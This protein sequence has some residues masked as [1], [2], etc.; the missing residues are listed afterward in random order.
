MT[1]LVLPFDAFIRTIGIH[2]NSPHALFLGAGASI[3]SGV[4]SA[5]M[6]VWEWKRNIFL[7]NHPGLEDQFSEL[8][9]ESVKIRIQDWLDAQGKFPIQHHP[10][11]YSAFIEAC[12]PIPDSRRAYFQEKVKAAKPFTGY[13]LL[14]LLAE[15]EL[16]RS[17]W[18][19]N[20]DGLTLKSATEFEI[21][22]V[23]VGIDSQERLPRTPTKGELLYIAMHGDYRYDSLMNTVNELRNQEEHLRQQLINLISNT[24]FIFSGYKGGDSSIM[25]ALTTGYSQPGTGALYWCGY[26]AEIPESVKSLICAARDAGRTAYFIPTR[27]FD[28]V[29]SSLARYCLKGESL[30]KAQKIISSNSTTNTSHRKPF[31]I[32][33]LPTNTLIKS[34]AFELVC[35]SEVFAFEPRSW[36]NK[37][38]W[39]W[40]RGITKGHEIVAVPFKR[41]I[42]LGVLDNIKDVFGDLIKGA[43]ERVPVDEHDFLF[44]DGAM[45]SLMK[46][47]L[48][49]SLATYANLNTDGRDILWE[50]SSYKQERFENQNF[51]I[52][53][54]VIVFIRRMSGRL[55]LVLKPSVIITDSNEQP[56]PEEISKILKNKVLSNQYNK[57]FNQ[58]MNCWRIK[59][60]DVKDEVIFEYPPNCGSTFRF[61]VRKAPL[62]AAMGKSGQNRPVTI[63]PEIVPMVKQQGVMIDEPSLVFSNKSGSSLVKDI[64]PI[65][66]L[67][68]ARPY[69]YSLTLQ[70]LVSSISLGIICPRNETRKLHTYLHQS[71][72]RHP[73]PQSMQNHLLD[74][75]GFNTAYGTPLEIPSP[76]EDG[77]ITCP[78]PD[79][80]LD[81][82]QGSLELARFIT[83]GISQLESTQKP[84]VIVIFIPDRWKTWNAFETDDENFDLHDFV[85]AYAVQT[86]VS[87]QFLREDTLTDQYPCRV[88]WWL[89]IALYAK[90]MRTPWVL[91]S[92][93]PDT[94]F[95]GL[96]FE[97]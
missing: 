10:D 32:D 84:S 14:C 50:I 18:T 75:P 31:E 66:G 72:A 44:E 61:K 89:S 46:S 40:L 7:T 54:A 69:D 9:L 58:E 74:Y 4:P 87:T 71:Q 78:E 97:I 12:Y 36:P 47:A 96:G 93:D 26:G 95:V 82:K 86:G 52:F 91:D 22:P 39:A 24:S 57:Q 88:W 80:N 34:N 48:I 62:F 33:I 85:K 55:Y 20:F 51:Q 3:T 94:A 2:R 56:A 21:V 6:C 17:V 90:S 64:H 19:T 41:I 45:N 35:P 1:D 16:I 73:A 38:T 53:R 67:V 77:W 8:S 60:F 42:C 5:Q 83:Q 29:M 15:Q 92:L 81:A 63:A 70:G 76:G 30:K 27:G 49:N 68:Q 79:A 65:R 43:V 11:E 37:K 13:K 25:E 28:D 59:L 23:E